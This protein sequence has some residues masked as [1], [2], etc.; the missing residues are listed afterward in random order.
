M[1]SV[2][3]SDNLSGDIRT[4]VGDI[5]NHLL[6]D[7]SLWTDIELEASQIKT[8]NGPL[9]STRRGYLDFLKHLFKCGV[10]FFTDT[11][12]GM[13]VAFFVPKLVHGKTVQRQR[14]VLDC[15]AVNL[16][17]RE[18]PRTELGSLASPSEVQIP[19]GSDLYMATADICDCFYACDC[20]AVLL[21][22][23]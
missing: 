18:P 17:F 23:P 9:L 2:S 21:P 6:Q 8:Y 22:I 11:C 16:Q 3:L 19:E 7:A 12:R 20:T 4:M 15:R 5:E 13:V 10:L 14:L 1:A